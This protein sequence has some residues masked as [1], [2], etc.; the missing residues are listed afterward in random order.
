MKTAYTHKVI[1]AVRELKDMHPKNIMVYRNIWA[2]QLS[3]RT[4]CFMKN[5]H[6]FVKFCV[7]RIESLSS[8]RWLHFCGNIILKYGLHLMWKICK[9]NVTRQLLQIFNTFLPV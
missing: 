4:V 6:N 5:P 9:L 2:I 7:H 8:S 1:L 3:S